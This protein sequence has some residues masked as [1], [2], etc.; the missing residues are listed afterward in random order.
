MER[1]E[2]EELLVKMVFMI[3]IWVILMIGSEWL[4]DSDWRERGVLDALI[5]NALIWGVRMAPC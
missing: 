4:D 2:L 3:V 5:P 1:W